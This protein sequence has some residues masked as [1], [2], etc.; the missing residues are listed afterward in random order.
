MG[1]FT[2]SFGA[3]GGY[4]ASSKAI[5]KSLVQRSHATLYATS[6][7]PP[8]V[9]Q[10]IASMKQIMGVDGSN[11][12]RRRI[13]QLAENAKFFRTELKKLGFIVY[14]NEASP[15]VPMLLFMPA[16]IAAFSR[17]MKKRKIAVVVVGFPA[18]PIIESRARFCLSAS[19]TREDLIKALVRSTL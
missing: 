2:K 18:C 16:K 7:S 4:I 8:V 10:C 5:I 11:L 15:I 3:A 17:E 19:H 13:Q 9:Q 14:G 1:T 12:G 6:M